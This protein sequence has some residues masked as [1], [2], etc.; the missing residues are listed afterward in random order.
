[1]R[2]G[3]IFIDRPVL[4]AVTSILVTIFGII[5]YPTLPVAQ[6]P[7]IVP[8]TVTVTATYPGASPETLADTVANPIEEQINGVENMIYMSSNSTGDGRVQITCTFKLGTDLNVSQVLVQN[9]VQ[10]ANPRLPQQVQ[11]TGVIVRKSSPDLLMGIHFTSPDHSLSRQYIANFVTL[12]V[13]DQVLRTEG[14][15]DVIIRGQ[16]DYA[17]R[18]WIDPD[19]AAARNLTSDEIVSALQTHNIQVAAGNLNAPP[20]GKGG[21]GYQLNIQALGG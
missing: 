6:Y 2:F 9:R 16:R 7:E 12:N 8:P 14:V 19:R 10:N 15:G 17:M 3:H 21:F 5:A 18:I 1:M 4:A 13:R 20:F 11:A